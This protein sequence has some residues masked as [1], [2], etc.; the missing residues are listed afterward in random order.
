MYDIIE[1]HYRDNFDRLVSAYQGRVGH[2]N[3][4][5]VVQE[6]Y[7]RALLYS[8]SF[9]DERPIDHWINQILRNCAADHYRGIVPKEPEEVLESMPDDEHFFDP[10]RVVVAADLLAMV[11]KLAQGRKEVHAAILEAFYF[12]ELTLNQ[13]A[14]RCRCHP[15]MAWAVIRKFRNELKDLGLA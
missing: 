2:H 10:E 1:Q 11:R 5:D 8:K 13:T 12:D 6:A 7:T 4:E 9:S 15:G 14:R 3:A